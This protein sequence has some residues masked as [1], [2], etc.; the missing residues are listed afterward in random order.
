[1]DLQEIINEHLE[2]RQRNARLEESL[3]LDRYRSEPATTEPAPAPP[4]RFLDET[5]EFTP[6]WLPVSEPR[7]SR[8]ERDDSPQLWDVPPLFDWGD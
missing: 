6:G 7:K 4:E 5:E 1:V 8:R 2:L 3:P